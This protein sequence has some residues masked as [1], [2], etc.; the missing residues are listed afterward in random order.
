MGYG[1]S[2]ISAL[3]D[4]HCEIVGFI[5]NDPQKIDTLFE[6]KSVIH[7]SDIKEQWDYIIVSV[8]K[9]DAIMYQLEKEG[10]ERSK[11]IFYYSEDCFSRFNDRL[12]IDEKQWKIDILEER[13]LQLEHCLKIRQKNFPYEF[14]AVVEQLKKTI[15]SFISDDETITKIKNGSSIIRFGDGEFD[16]IT[17]RKSPVFQE[18]SMELAD[19]LKDVLQANKNKL[20]I[21]IAKNYGDLS[22]Y[23]DDVADGIREYMTDDVRRE[24]ANLLDLNRAYCDAYMFKCF[25][26]HRDRDRTIE[27]IRKIQQIWDNKDVFLIEG[28]YT[29]TGVGND[30]LNNVRSLKRI[31][32]PTKD[33][34][35]IYS[36]LLEKCLQ[37]IDKDDLILIALGPAGKVLAYDLFMQ[38]YH[39]VDIG[40][41]DMDYE[42]YLSGTGTKVHNP[43]KYVSQLPPAHIEDIDDTEYTNQIIETIG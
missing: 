8:V 11:L 22:M 9:Y 20:L 37:I 13:I 42:W 7:L 41:M 21:A 36:I 29:R 33:A 39:V 3:I 32:C 1:R 16:L 26:P 28:K 15:P 2:V 12:F 43:Y 31:L 27:R 6:G 38:G 35:S 5:D 10:I 18:Y 4:L 34:Y 25:I 30:L 14:A 19:R 24:H 17:K 40:Q 23:P